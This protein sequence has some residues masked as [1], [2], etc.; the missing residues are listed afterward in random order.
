MIHV[1]LSL[2]FIAFS[3]LPS[4]ALCVSVFFWYR[5]FRLIQLR[6]R[7]E[8][9]T[10]DEQRAI[11]YSMLFLPSLYLTHH[12][13]VGDTDRS[14]LVF[15]LPSFSHV[16]PFPSFLLLKLPLVVMMIFWLKWNRTIGQTVR[17][18]TRVFFL[19]RQS[20]R[21]LRYDLRVFLFPSLLSFASSLSPWPL[22]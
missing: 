5:Y 7:V 21:V 10:F 15:P 20:I 17:Q 18:T 4:F 9:D 2:F 11:E 14:F 3:I 1:S 13:I 16:H 19:L 6:F 22:H 8:N 12:F